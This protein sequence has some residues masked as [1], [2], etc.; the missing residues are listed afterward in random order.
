M[1]VKD[2]QK[3]A[4]IVT[5]RLSEHYPDAKVHL[6]YKNAFQLII[7]TVLAA[8]C[9]DVLVNK[10]MGPL[11]KEK[12]KGP[13]DII[14]AGEAKFRDDIKLINFYAN[15]AR[16]V[17]GLCKGLVENYGGKV[18]DTMQELVALP[19]VGRK[20]ASVILGNIYG[21]ENV[22]IIDTHVIR[23]G[24]RLGLTDQK[25]ADKIEKDYQKLI[26]PKK[27]FR[28]SVEISEHGRVICDARF[29]KCPICF[30]NDICP[31]AYIVMPE[32]KKKDAPKSK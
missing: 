26:P 24:G 30:M 13:E 5:K 16:L 32:S 23:V 2:R 11:Y 18:P 15:K 29:P 3:Q 4:D 12:Y 6:D 9:R 7:S 14:K 31:S 8:Q 22:L 1:L 17:I 27:Q 20:S 28:F 19:G 21:V 10:V 25:V